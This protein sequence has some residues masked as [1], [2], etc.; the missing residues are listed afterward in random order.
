MEDFADDLSL[1][2]QSAGKF[3][4][5][6]YQLTQDEEEE[7]R[8]EVALAIS[9][10][11]K[12]KVPIEAREAYVR[13]IARNVAVTYFR[14]KKRIASLD[15]L[16]LLEVEPCSKDSSEEPLRRLIREENERLLFQALD[17]LSPEYRRVLLAVHLEGM[18]SATVA[19]AEGVKPKT[20]YTKLARAEAKLRE[21][22]KARFS[23]LY[24]GGGKRK[25]AS[26]LKDAYVKCR[27]RWSLEERQVLDLH[28]LEG[29]DAPSIA[30]QLLP[31]H[32]QAGDS[33][34]PIRHLL[35]QAERDLTSR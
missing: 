25:G 7:L 9:E 35:E 11:L 31:A 24:R 26:S 10:T 15:E 32:R 16:R 28:F 27:D 23:T 8:Q 34:Q 4:V 13:A 19:Q 21:R 3:L 6:R 30:R 33:E 17:S 22:L 20:I 2:L 18:D 14:K 12:K 29:K 1:I 5:R